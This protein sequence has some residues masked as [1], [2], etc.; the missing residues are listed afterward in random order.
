MAPF[1]QIK[2][3]GVESL[4]ACFT[5][6]SVGIADLPFPVCC[7]LRGYIDVDAM[8]DHFLMKDNMIK[9]CAEEA[10]IPVEIAQQVKPVSAVSY[11][12]QAQYG[13][14]PDILYVFDL[15][16]DPDFAPHNA[17]PKLGTYRLIVG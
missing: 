6:K 10:A 16:L 4:G 13:L 11:C 2:V 15:Q 5:E 3:S 17:D 7:E 12:L 1:H 14:R 8:V 9:E